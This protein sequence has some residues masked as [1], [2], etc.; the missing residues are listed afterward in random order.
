MQ[1][2]FVMW[3]KVRTFAYRNK[4]T[5]T[6][7]NKNDNSI[8]AIDGNTYYI[9]LCPDC[10]ENEGG[11]YVEIYKDWDYTDRYD[12]LC[13]GTKKYRGDKADCDLHNIDSIMEYIEGYLNGN[14]ERM[15]Y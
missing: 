8:D 6:M 11:F 2:Y 9:T 10:G 3:G 12:Y 1:K 7:Y 15:G 5:N 13:I 4:A 14:L